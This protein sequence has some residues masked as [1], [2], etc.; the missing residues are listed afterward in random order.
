[1]STY[2]SHSLAE[3]REGLNRRISFHLF[4]AFMGVG[5]EGLRKGG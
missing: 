4:V 3:E 1:M 2:V 5:G